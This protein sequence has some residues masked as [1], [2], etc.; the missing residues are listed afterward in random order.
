MYKAFTFLF[1]L[2]SIRCSPIIPSQDFAKCSHQSTTDLQSSSWS[3]F[4]ESGIYSPVQ[5]N[6]DH[7]VKRLKHTL[8]ELAAII[9]FHKEDYTQ[10]IFGESYNKIDKELEDLSYPSLI[11]EYS[12]LPV[13]SQSSLLASYSVFQHLA[14][15]IEVVITDHQ[16]HQQYTSKMWRLTSTT[17]ENILRNIYSELVM[18]GIS[19]P[20]PLARN[21]IPDTMRCVS[22]SSYRD[23]RDFIVL[24][25]IMQAALSYSARLE[26]A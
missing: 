26:E 25:H 10:D 8:A 13:L 9:D 17:V 14:I 21:V 22:F 2:T 16:H 23:T 1:T 3:V 18:K 4:L 7:H 6:T 20:A 12:P 19:I 24:R 5:D 15:S 11:S